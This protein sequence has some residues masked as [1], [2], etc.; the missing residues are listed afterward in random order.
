MN[1][2]KHYQLYQLTQTLQIKTHLES[3]HQ[4]LQ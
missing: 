1:Y 4:V 3:H 2:H